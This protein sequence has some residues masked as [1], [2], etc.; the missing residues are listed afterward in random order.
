[1]LHLVRS[2]SSW[3]KSKRVAARRCLKPLTRV[4]ALVAALM[5]LPAAPAIAQ[6][7]IENSLRFEAQGAALLLEHYQIERT[8][9]APDP[10]RLTVFLS[11]QPGSPL[12]LDEVTLWLDGRPLVRHRY[13]AAELSR[14][15]DGAVQPLYIGA[16]ASGDHQLKLEA[17]TRLG[18]LAPMNVF[19]FAKSGQPR[20]I[21]LRITGDGVRQIKAAAW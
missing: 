13:T 20:Y 14:L 17:R 2:I 10:D 18:K 19:S 1:M 21:E 11:T 16:L 15:A 5:L 7:A 4:I 9:L 6:S 3:R 8:M 12:S